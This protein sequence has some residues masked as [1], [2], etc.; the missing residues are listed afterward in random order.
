MGGAINSINDLLSNP[1]FGKMDLGDKDKMMMQFPEYSGMPEQDREKVLQVAHYGSIQP[2]TPGYKEPGL[3]SGSYILP[4]EKG[5]VDRPGSIAP[6]ESMP[7]AV[8]RQ[9]L[10][11]LGRA[12]EMVPQTVIGA[13]KALGQGPQT[14]QEA[15]I[16]AAGGTPM[17]A[18]ERIGT[19]LLS[20]PQQ[21]YQEAKRGDIG[22]MTEFGGA[23]LA[24]KV[25][26][27]G[28][29]GLSKAAKAFAPDIDKATENIYAALGTPAGRAG[30]R[31]AQME[32]DITA[33]KP[34]LAKIERA[35]PTPRTIRQALT[36]KG[37][38][39]WFG[40]TADKIADY[41]ADLWDKA[42]NEQVGRHSEAPFDNQT[43][44][45]NSLGSINRQDDMRQSAKAREW[46]EREIPRIQTL[47]DADQR[48]RL[49]N[50]EIKKLPEKYG[51]VGARVRMAVVKSL[52]DQLD[53][54]LE[55][56][57]ESG[58]KENNRAY[59]ALKNIE[60]RLR[61]R[62]YQE[63]GK[64][65]KAS[66]IPDW[67]HAYVFT[68][69][70]GAAIGAGLRLNKMF[71]P[72]AAS[73]LR[74]G[75]AT[76]AKSGLEP[77]PIAGPPA[78]MLR[79]IKGYLTAGPRIGEP[80]PDESYVRGTTAAAEP[81]TVAGRLRALPPGEGIG[82]IQMPP[83]P[84]SPLAGS[85]ASGPETRAYPT[86]PQPPLR[87]GGAVRGAK[88]LPAVPV[89]EEMAQR[90]LPPSTT[91]F[92]QG[93][94]EAGPLAVRTP[95]AIPAPPAMA[96]VEPSRMPEPAPLPRP[97]LPKTET[98]KA[99]GKPKEQANPVAE[100]VGGPSPGTI[101][102][103]YRFIGGDPSD[104]ANWVEVITALSNPAE[105]KK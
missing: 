75:M 52:R 100:H 37:D 101:E 97:E 46:A 67:L 74:S 66:P 2:G 99:T 102:D 65:T 44:L 70:G 24:P 9:A 15:V 89:A 92:Y 55:S 29:E 51:P 21:L 87:Y 26:E 63:T 17:L 81:M 4:V 42:H 3:L 84:L 105:V 72:E 94:G 19:G 20:W 8:V 73:Q 83:S 5:V 14:G 32:Q 90:A 56:L 31:A 104:K 80:A 38:P 57:G 77:E 50:D 40:Q 34:H 28:Q 49:L 47:G 45:R 41:K 53:D 13:A 39:E 59:G 10:G 12:A 64:A 35:E 61:E 16:Q 11:G 91:R 86:E 36:G 18:A 33:A 79:P 82:P 76:L 71:A 95:A 78:G 96:A 62:H 85:A 68:H 25:G 23:M 54:Q 7:H 103:G 30:Q 1:E 22:A 88:A 27:F 98:A 60:D 93:M 43:T 48:I 58:V 69:P 6:G